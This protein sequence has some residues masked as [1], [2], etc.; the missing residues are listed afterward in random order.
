MKHYKTFN[1]L[2]FNTY[3]IPDELKPMFKSLGLLL[4]SGSKIFFDNGYGVSV[5]N[6]ESI[7]GEYELAIITSEDGGII[8]DT[9]ITNDV[10]TNLTKDDVT[11]YMREIQDLPARIL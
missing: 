5:I 8:Y 9:P 2:V 6:G 10:I 11:R 1:D 3:D 7:E 4:N